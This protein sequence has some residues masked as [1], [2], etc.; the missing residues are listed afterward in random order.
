MWVKTRQEVELGIELSS[1]T[2]TLIV[3]QP[4]VANAVIAIDENGS[5]EGYSVNGSDAELPLPVVPVLPHLREL[6]VQSEIALP[7]NIVFSRVQGDVSVK[8]EQPALAS[9]F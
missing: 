1:L 4:T 6:L 2:H 7:T 5:I 3:M 9:I 8:I